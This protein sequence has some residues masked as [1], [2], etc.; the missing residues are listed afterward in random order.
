V[1]MT[2]TVITFSRFSTLIKDIIL[3]ASND[4]LPQSILC[5]VYSPPNWTN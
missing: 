4:F 3:H 1:A 5:S 2:A